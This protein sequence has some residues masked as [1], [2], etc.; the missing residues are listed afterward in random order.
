MHARNLHYSPEFYANGVDMT[1]QIEWIFAAEAAAIMGVSV[2]NVAY[3]CRKGKLTCQKWGTTWQVSKQD[4]ENYK[5]SKRD[6]V[7]LYNAD[8]DE[9]S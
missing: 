3:L 5:R 8:E 2:G 4:A 7:W 6:P 1:E 9:Q